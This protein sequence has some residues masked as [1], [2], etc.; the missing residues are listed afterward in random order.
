MKDWQLRVIEEKHELDRKLMSL[1][2][3]IGSEDFKK[4]SPYVQNILKTQKNIM[5][6]Y[7]DC[8]LSRI[9]YFHAYT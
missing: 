1:S 4:E 7:S 6:E 5:L 9:V 8:L 2:S 3:F